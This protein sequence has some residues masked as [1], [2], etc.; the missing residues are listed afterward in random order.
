[1]CVS[2]ITV[3]GYSSTRF[4]PSSDICKFCCWAFMP[5]IHATK[6]T[7]KKKKRA[8]MIVPFLSF[9]FVNLQLITLYIFFMFCPYI[10]G[11]VAFARKKS[12][13][14]GDGGSERRFYFI[15]IIFLVKRCFPACS[16]YIY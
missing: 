9:L 12:L 7:M 5:N 13:H 3:S 8:F 2:T 6:R 14:F 11:K 4:H 16:A 15:S 1:F 10:C